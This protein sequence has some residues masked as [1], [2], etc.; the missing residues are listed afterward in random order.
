MITLKHRCNM[1]PKKHLVSIQPP[2]RTAPNP[3]L[4]KNAR[5]VLDS[6]DSE[7][8]I[9]IDATDASALP[10]SAGMTMAFG[11]TAAPDPESRT[12]LLVPVGEKQDEAV[13]GTRSRTKKKFLP[14]P[15]LKPSRG[16]LIQDI[17]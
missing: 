12:E 4:L 10:A 17:F 1:A 5:N 15:R 3:A 6:S 14:V 7:D 2:R 16:H 13:T 8:C 9:Q 11:G